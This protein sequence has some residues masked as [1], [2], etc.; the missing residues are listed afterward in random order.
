MHVMGFMVDKTKPFPKQRKQFLNT[1][2]V[3][4]FVVKEYKHTAVLASEVD[5]AKYFPNKQRKHL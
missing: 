4:M 3:F 1:I 5:R 2:M